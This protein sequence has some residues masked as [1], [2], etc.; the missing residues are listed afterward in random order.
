MKVKTYVMKGTIMD[1]FDK[2]VICDVCRAVAVFMIL[3]LIFSIFGYSKTVSDYNAYI[4]AMNYDKFIAGEMLK[5]MNIWVAYGTMSFVMSIVSI[6][7]YIFVN[8]KC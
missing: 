2:Q 5:Q 3:Y 4:S 7:T 8:Q 6:I 1:E